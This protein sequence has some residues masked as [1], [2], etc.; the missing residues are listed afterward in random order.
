ML[1]P[2]LAR[3]TSWLTPVEGRH[4]VHCAWCFWAQYCMES[5]GDGRSAPFLPLIGFQVVLG[6]CLAHCGPSLQAGRGARSDTAE[7]AATTLG[8]PQLLSGMR[9]GQHKLVLEGQMHACTG[10]SRQSRY[11]VA[12]DANNAVLICLT[13]EEGSS[14]YTG[15]FFSQ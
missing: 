4:L 3:S 14:T 2:A 11:S 7:I 5:W 13:L 8:H 9:G 1:R 10:Y 6:H 12:P 15:S